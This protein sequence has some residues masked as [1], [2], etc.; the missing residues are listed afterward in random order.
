MWVLEY[1]GDVVVAVDGLSLA[2]RQVAICQTKG[3]VFEREAEKKRALRVVCIRWRVQ[4]MGV[5]FRIP[6]SRGDLPYPS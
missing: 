3:C 2:G 5:S 6:C 4:E 1:G